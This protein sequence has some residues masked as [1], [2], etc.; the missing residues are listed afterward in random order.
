MRSESAAAYL[1][2][3]KRFRERR[4]ISEPILRLGAN[5]VALLPYQIDL[6]GSMANTAQSLASLAMFIDYLLTQDPI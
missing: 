4:L 6:S 1:A 3:I 2:K 5:E